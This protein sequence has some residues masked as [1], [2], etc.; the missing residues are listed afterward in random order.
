MKK[1]ILGISV[2]VVIAIGALASKLITGGDDE[3]L[4]PANPQTNTTQN[5]NSNNTSTNAATSTSSTY[6]DGSYTGTVNNFIYGSLQ[7]KIIVTGGKITDISYPQY[8]NHM[9][10]TAEV[11]S[12][13]LP[14][15]KQEAIQNQNSKVDI[16][17]GATQTSEAFMQTL[18]SALSQAI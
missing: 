17:S 9:G 1:I 3:K 10:H 18:Q 14:I 12:Y 13:A 6:K 2:I 5:T 8:P 16:I 7:V 4:G 15:L 11:S